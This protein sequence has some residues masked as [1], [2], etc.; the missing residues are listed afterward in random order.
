MISQNDNC[1]LTCQ[2]VCMKS[3]YGL[4][5]CDCYKGY[6]LG[7]EAG[8]CEDINECNIMG[9]CSQTCINTIGHFKVFIYS[10]FDSLYVVFNQFI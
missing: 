4:E 10:K 1:T 3:K 8:K 2:H 6:K 5:Y 7:D 9:S